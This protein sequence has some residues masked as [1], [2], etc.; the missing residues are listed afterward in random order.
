MSMDHS[1]EN[2]DA[3]L[4]AAH[5]FIE[6]HRNT[7]LPTSVSNDEHETGV[8]TSAVDKAKKSVVQEEEVLESREKR[9]YGQN[10]VPSQPCD[11]HKESRRPRD[12]IPQGVHVEERVKRA[13]TMRQVVVTCPAC[14]YERTVPHTVIPLIDWPPSLTVSFLDE[15]LDAGEY[16]ASLRRIGLLVGVRERSRHELQERL[17]SEGFS[18]DAVGTAIDKAL[19]FS[20]IDDSRYARAFIMG[21]RASGWGDMRI[22]RE[23]ERSGVEGVVIGEVVRIIDGQDGPDEFERALGVLS[24]HHFPAHRAHDA[25]FRRLISKGFSSDLSSRVATRY[26]GDHPEYSDKGCSEDI[27]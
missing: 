9:T 17:Q 1:Y 24:H 23:L 5:R 7:T 27:L 8:S 2:G 19:G 21:K 13:R 3:Q 6:A 14:E 20:W 4:Q 12:T 18:E 22:R 16:R 10:R 26:L 25:M 11:T 15:A